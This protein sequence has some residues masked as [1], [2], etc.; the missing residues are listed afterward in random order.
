MPARLRLGERQVGEQVE[1]RGVER[2]ALGTPGF[3][4]C[5]EPILAGRVGLEERQQRLPEP[6]WIHGVLGHGGRGNADEP[7]EVMIPVD[8]L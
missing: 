8:G 5:Q 6:D 3:Q 4:L 2:L 7:A 1:E